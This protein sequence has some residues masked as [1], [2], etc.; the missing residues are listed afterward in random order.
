MNRELGIHELGPENVIKW[1]CACVGGSY[2]PLVSTK[3]RQSGSIGLPEGQRPQQLLLS[4][5]SK[6]SSIPEY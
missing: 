4:L 6:A 2:K 3:K 5:F 1:N